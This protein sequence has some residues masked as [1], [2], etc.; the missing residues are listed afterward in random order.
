MEIGVPQSILYPS[1]PVSWNLDTGVGCTEMVWNDFSGSPA[2]VS[3]L[4]PS[5]GIIPAYIPDVLGV[6]S[7]VLIQQI[8][9]DPAVRTAIDNRSHKSG[10]IMHTFYRGPRYLTM[11]ALILGDY[12]EYREMVSEQMRGAMQNVMAR[13]GRYIYTP[14]NAPTRFL[15][16]RHYE[17]LKVAHS[18]STTGTAVGVSAPKTS[19]VTLVAAD[20]AAYTLEQRNLY[21]SDSTGHITVPNS[22]NTETWPIIRVHGPFVSPLVSNHITITNNDTGAQ[23]KMQAPEGIGLEGYPSAYYEIDMQQETITLVGVPGSP[24]DY[25]S[26]LDPT[27]SDFFSIAPGGADISSNIWGGAFPLF[28]QTQILSRD[29]WA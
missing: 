23:L 7:G 21:V 14:S 17:A 8:T 9:E 15:T 22:G 27:V 4:S 19:L 3:G 12:P 20:W 10:G 25:L 28:G 6:G 13:D 16:V 24:I 26:S 2:S 11:E 29:A 1:D 5:G 18:T